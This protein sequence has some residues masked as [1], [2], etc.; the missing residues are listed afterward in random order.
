MA[1][2]PTT[3]P[4]S[5]PSLGRPAEPNPTLRRAPQILTIG[6]PDGHYP[7]AS[8]MDQAGRRVGRGT[9]PRRRVANY[10]VGQRR[11]RVQTALLV[12]HR[13][14]NAPPLDCLVACPSQSWVI[15]P[16]IPQDRDSPV[17]E[18]V[19]AFTTSTML[20]ARPTTRPKTGALLLQRD[21]ALLL[22]PVVN[23]P[24]RGRCAVAFGAASFGC[25]SLEIFKVVAVSATKESIFP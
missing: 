11:R 12:I 24:S 18:R 25:T 7:N 19:S 8:E 16:K 14:P 13:W 5:G 15:Y 1:A 23:M 6:G 9:G 2:R 3:R 10:G 4:K 21:M 20:A 17:V 22:A